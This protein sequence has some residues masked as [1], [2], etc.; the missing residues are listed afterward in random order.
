[1]SLHTW[2][3]RVQIRQ[4]L[5]CILYMDSK[6]STVRSLLEINRNSINY[7]ISG[8]S[9]GTKNCLFSKGYLG[10]LPEETSEL[11]LNLKSLGWDDYDGNSNEK[12]NCL[13]FFEM[14][15]D[16]IK[17]FLEKDTRK[18]VNNILIW[19]DDAHNPNNVDLVKFSNENPE[20]RVFILSTYPYKY[21]EQ[22]PDI[23]TNNSKNLIWFPHASA[24]RFDIGINYDSEQL[25]SVYGKTSFPYPHRQRIVALSKEES[26][27]DKILVKKHPGYKRS[28]GSSKDLPHF[29][30]TFLE[31]IDF[32]KKYSIGFTC[33]LDPEK[34]NYAVAKIFEIPTSGQLLMVN[35][36]LSKYLELLGFKDNVNCLFYNESNMKEKVNYVLNMNKDDVN[37]IRKAGHELNIK[38]HTLDRRCE[39]LNNIV[40]AVYDNCV[41]VGRSK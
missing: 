25:L 33:G 34:Y 3:E 8:I 36:E 11:Y 17:S 30:E 6:P 20:N 12:I 35:E 27:K 40:S 16:S 5:C 26:F 23:I 4:I 15:V 22:F 18:N 7:L 13:F 29:P 38:H 28:E 14:G 10:R 32:V 21:I 37:S 24:K 39:F 9:K 2:D 31:T 19:T 1:M 41:T